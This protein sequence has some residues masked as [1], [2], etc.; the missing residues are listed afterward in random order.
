MCCAVQVLKYEP[1]TQPALRF[2]QGCI[3]FLLVHY[4]FYVFGVGFVLALA[5][6]MNWI[7][8]YVVVLVVGAYLPFYFNGA[9]K[10]I[11]E[12]STCPVPCSC[13]ASPLMPVVWVR[14]GDCRRAVGRLQ[15]ALVLGVNSQVLV[16]GDHS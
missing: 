2:L 5:L 7:A 8:W 3:F 14:C 11:G 4:F 13:S 9:H 12:R 16:G 10:K 6:Y 15:T 1:E